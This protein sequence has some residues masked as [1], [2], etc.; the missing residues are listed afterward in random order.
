M[1]WLWLWLWFSHW[2]QLC[3]MCTLDENCFGKW[4]YRNQSMQTIKSRII[5]TLPCYD[6]RVCVC[7]WF[8]LLTITAIVHLSSALSQ[9]FCV[10]CRHQWR[11][12]IET[13][14]WIEFSIAL[15]V[16]SAHFCTNWDVNLNK[17]FWKK[18]SP[19]HQTVLSIKWNKASA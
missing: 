18:K 12:L 8:E 6:V 11:M 15:S 19:S 16:R 1:A 13:N 9:W 3:G 14:S 17:Y 2:S 4:F 7:V 10:R 5:T